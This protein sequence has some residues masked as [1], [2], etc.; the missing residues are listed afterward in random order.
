[1][2]EQFNISFLICVGNKNQQPIIY[3]KKGQTYW[4]Q[5]DID[6]YRVA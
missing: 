3:I 1:M 6:I 4:R 5:K 2:I